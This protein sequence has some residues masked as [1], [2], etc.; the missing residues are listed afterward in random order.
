M[1]YYGPVYIIN[2]IGTDPYKT[3]AL[4]TTSEIISNSLLFF[5][6]TRIPRKSSGIVS[7]IICAILNGILIFFRNP[8]QCDFCAKYYIEISIICIARLILSIYFSI[9]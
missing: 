3:Q 6:I 8:D 2:Q 1:L 9:F 4:L 5:S 7:L